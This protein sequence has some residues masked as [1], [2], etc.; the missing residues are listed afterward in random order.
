[1]APAEAARVLSALTILWLTAGN[2]PGAMTFGYHRKCLPCVPR[3]LVFGARRV[4]TSLG[5]ARGS[6]MTTGRTF[7]RTL[8][9]C[10]RTL[11]IVLILISFCGIAGGQSTLYIDDNAV[12]GGDGASWGTAM[13][14]LQTAL[15]A[16]AAP[17][18]G[19]T[20]LHV[21]QGRYVPTHRTDRKDPRSATFR[22]LNGVALKG[23]Y[24]GLGARNPDERDPEA[25]P[26]VLSGDING[27]DQPEFVNISENVYH[28]LIGSGTNASAVV[29]GFT[30][31][32][33]NANTGEFPVTSCFGGGAL[34][35]GGSPSF[36]D[37]VFT[38]NWADYGGGMYNRD[39]SSPTITGC[40]FLGNIAIFDLGGIG[41]AIRNYGSSSPIISYCEFI[42]N[43][44]DAGG[45]IAYR[46]SSEPN[47]SHCAFVAN[48]AGAGG[49]IFVHP[50]NPPL[51][52]T[53]D[54]CLFID[55]TALAGAGAALLYSTINS[56]VTKCTFK[57]NSTDYAGGG[58]FLSGAATL[59]GCTIEKNESGWLAG[60]ILNNANTTLINCEI[61]QNAA[62]VGGGIY[63]GGPPLTLI[64]CS[65]AGNGNGGITGFSTISGPSQ[66]FVKNSVIWGN[67]GGQ[68]LADPGQI[69]SNWNP[70]VSFTDI[71]GGW[72][73]L[74]NLNLDPLFIQPGCGNL[75]LAYGSLCINAGNNAYVPPNVT[76]DLAGNIRIQNGTVDM[77]AYEG[78]YD[79]L[80]LT[81]CEDNLD[82]GYTVKLMPTGG[83]VQSRAKD[84]LG[85]H[86]LQR[87]R[88]R[89]GHGHAD[90]QRFAFGGGRFQRNGIDPHR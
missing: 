45:A 64:N 49:A 63:T 57:N 22:L 10:P 80:P 74:G 21:A 19:V 83:R 82:D 30:I 65:I 53:I 2:R 47:V 55:N 71:Q 32:G 81:A 35:V 52:S 62:D 76:T 78:G 75:R 26:S 24:A 54:E 31:T 5:F 13:N 33:G 40:T 46:L 7:W 20:E 12:R 8:L 16:A 72:I 89:L 50:D 69:P 42:E 25:F 38:A 37:C 56:V 68:I 58:L 61:S 79:M 67:T 44:S 1:M 15:N 27:D 73:G 4:P 34:N 60:G 87:A 14:K 41:G 3:A 29:D 39:A 77:G 59:T 84:R 66:L 90:R 51:Y 11:I 85:L 36:I 18:S 70:F 28:V 9:G 6:I 48:T 43:S 17:R 86:Q 23:G 88:Q